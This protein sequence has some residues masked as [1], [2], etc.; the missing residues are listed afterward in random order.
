MPHGGG[1]RRQ[2]LLPVPRPPALLTAQQPYAQILS[3]D[4]SATTN[5]NSNSSGGTAGSST[6][7]PSST[8]LRCPRLRRAPL[9]V[10]PNRA[11]PAAP[12][13]AYPDIGVGLDDFTADDVDALLLQGQ[14]QATVGFHQSPPFVD[15]GAGGGGQLDQSFFLGPPRTPP[16][17]TDPNGPRASSAVQSSA[18]DG[19]EETKTTDATAFPGGDGDHAALASAFFSGQNGENIDMLNMAFLKGMEEAKKFLPTN[20]SLLIDLEDTSG[21]SL[22]TDSKPATGFT[23]AQVKEEEEVA[24]GILLFGGGGGGSTNGRAARTATPKMTY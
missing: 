12:L 4:D 11:L 1:H 7:S 9:A 19:Q 14:A 3:S 21:Q 5:S 6:L 13:P 10:R 18:S 22:P 8:S 2:V 17:T 15:T 16:V 23:A 24:D 20:N